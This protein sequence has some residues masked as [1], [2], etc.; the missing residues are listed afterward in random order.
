MRNQL[1]YLSLLLITVLSTSAQKVDIDQIKNNDTL[2]IDILSFNKEVMYFEVIF[3][4]FSCGLNFIA[5]DNYVR[6]KTEIERLISN[7]NSQYLKIIDTNYQIRFL[8]S[9]MKV[10]TDLLLNKIIPYWYGTKWDFNGY[11][12][13]P[14]QGTVACGYFV[15][16]TLKDMGLNLNRYK[17]AQQNPKYEAKSIA[18]DSNNISHF[19][20]NNIAEKLKEL[21]NGVY[22]VGLD[23]HVGYIYV[24]NTKSYFIHSNYIA[25][26]VMIETTTLSKAFRS[27]D[28]YIVKLTGNRNLAERWLTKKVME[29]I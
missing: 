25:G 13:I 6:T 1:K 20:E 14:N 17:L 12:A 29:I 5:D 8:D 18:V 4:S 10:F 27:Y 11:T 16:N 24:N 3:D 26:Q 28:Y 2:N 21:K 23:N 15:S 19:R 7:L 9:T 22:F